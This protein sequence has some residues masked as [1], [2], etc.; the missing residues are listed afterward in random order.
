MIRI[1]DDFYFAYVKYPSP[2]MM[3]FNNNGDLL[4][5]WT[6]IRKPEYDREPMQDRY[7]LMAVSFFNTLPKKWYNALIKGIEPYKALSR[8]IRCENGCVSEYILVKGEVIKKCKI[9]LST[10]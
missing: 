10:L 5:T 8:N 3:V 6:N 9:C 2:K 7:R 1:N 4:F